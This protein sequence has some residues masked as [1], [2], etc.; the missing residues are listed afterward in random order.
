MKGE[1]KKDL[2]SIEHAYILAYLGPIERYRE[3]PIR[4][5]EQVAASGD[6]TARL[7]PKYLH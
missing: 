5:Y 4:C 2:V 7:K 1:E 6:R 3:V